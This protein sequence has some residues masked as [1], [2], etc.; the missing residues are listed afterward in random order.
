MRQIASGQEAVRP[1]SFPTA[2]DRSHPTPFLRPKPASFALAKLVRAEGLEP[3]RL[4]P[5]EPKSD[6]STNSATPASKRGGSGVAAGWRS[7]ACVSEGAS[8]NFAGRNLADKPFVARQKPFR[9]VASPPCHTHAIRVHSSPWLE[10]GPLPIHRRHAATWL[11]GFAWRRVSWA[12]RRARR[13]PLHQFAGPSSPPRP[14]GPCA[15]R[16]RG[17]P[18]Y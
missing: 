9:L 1:I 6:A 3:P 2:L 14:R 18:P 12:E 16:R 8:L 5:P 4:A 7:I 13:A 15:R 10:I 17:R 11:S